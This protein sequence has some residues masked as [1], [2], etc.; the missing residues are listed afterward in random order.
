[1]GPD[2]IAATIAR[3]LKDNPT[4]LIVCHVAPDGDCLG[5]GLALGLALRHL[6]KSVTVASAD[7][8]PANLAFL[9][10]AD[11]VVRHPPDGATYA[12]AVT[13]EC[14]DLSRTGS[15][16]PAVRSS[17]TIIAIDHHAGH[18]PYAHLTDWDPAAAA[19]GEQVAHIIRLLG[20]EIDSL[21]ALAL[22]TALV[23]DTGAF[24]YGNTTAKTLRLAADLMDRG[25]TIGQI[26]RA[27]YEDQP[28]SA[29]RLLGHALAGLELHEDGAV[30]TAMITPEM[31]AGAGAV[32][33]EASGI[34]AML[35]T[36]AGVRLAMTFE[37]RVGKVRVSIRARDG[38]R[39][40]RVAAALG[41]GGHAAAAGAEP[42]GT[43]KDVVKRALQEARRELRRSREGAEFQRR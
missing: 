36:I 38:L 4:T 19:V 16:A 11:T 29:L 35:R 21:I 17:P 30:A 5:A 2:G 34:A 25:A 33:E 27:V 15:L 8:V 32:P 3:T 26:V 14:S 10:G 43:L 37:D 1:M 7:G 39:A 42:A 6:G 23:T 40:D 20:V 24:R 9:P 31:L 18:V 12:V 28:P 22:L 13:M 41:G